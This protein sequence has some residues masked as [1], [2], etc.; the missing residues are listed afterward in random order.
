MS[1][2]KIEPG[3]RERHASFTR[4]YAIGRYH[5]DCCDAQTPDP[6]QSF[7]DELVR[8]GDSRSTIW[9][10]DN[11]ANGAFVPTGWTHGDRVLCPECSRAVERFLD[12]RK[13]SLKDEVTSP[14]AGD[15]EILRECVTKATELAEDGLL[16]SYP[17]QHVHVDTHN[18]G[19]TYTYGIPG[20][21]PQKVFATR[22]DY[23][24]G[25]LRRRIREIYCALLGKPFD[26]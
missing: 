18:F 12:R 8:R 10:F 11:G 4:R 3:T 17:P 22:T 14:R 25:M 5:C 9:P 7:L 23:R 2:G 20:S 15:F 26:E 6:P 13:K 21:S 1:V 19:S 16:A 24:E